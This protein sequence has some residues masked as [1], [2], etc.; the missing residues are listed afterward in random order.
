MSVYRYRQYQAA[1]K[2]TPFKGKF[3]PY[4]WGELPS[5]LP[6]VWAPYAEMFREFSQ[7]IA[8]I[9]NDL[10]RYTHQLKAWR[11]VV[12]KLDDR[13]KLGVATEFVDPL[14]TIALNLPYAIRSRFILAT[15]H[16][17]HQAGQI[18]AGKGWKDDLP[19]D[20]EIYF[21]QADKAGKPWKKYSKLKTKLERIGDQ[22]YQTKTKNFRN[23]YNHRFSPRIVIGETNFVTRHV[24]PDTKRVS[25]GFG[26]MQPL[27]LKLVGEL[28]EQQ[29]DRCYKAF[30]AF[31]KLVREHEAVISTSAASMVAEMKKAP[32][33]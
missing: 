2:G 12:D 8:N 16:L 24:D 9:I 22:D 4:H 33:S 27:S 11:D 28:L 18:K 5:S 3:L 15:T 19:L 25:Y 29:C 30:E 1:L 6:F 26:G 10:T 21:E 13:G 32:K 14:A 7:E 23:T 20:D 31:H 17:C